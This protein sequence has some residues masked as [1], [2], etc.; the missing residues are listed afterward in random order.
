[1]TKSY[2]DLPF[3]GILLPFPYQKASAELVKL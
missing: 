3:Q 1:M 2:G